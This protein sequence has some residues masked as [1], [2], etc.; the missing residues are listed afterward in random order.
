MINQCKKFR[1]IWLVFGL[2]LAN[3]AAAFHLD[4]SVWMENGA[5]NTGFCRDTALGCDTLPVMTEL[6]LPADQ[7]PT[8]YADGRKMF[9]T[10]FGD[11]PGGAYSTDD[12]GFQAL[13]GWLPGDTLLQYRA[14][15]S[16]Q[17]WDPT[18]QAWTADIPDSTQI[19]LFGG[20]SAETVISTDTSHCGGLLICIP[21]SVEETVYN[22][23]STT[24]SEQGVG[25]AQ[26]L[27]IDNTTS[28]GALHAHLDWFLEQNDGTE[29]AANGAYLVAMQVIADGYQDSVPFYILFNNGLSVADLTTAIQAR[30][31]PI[32]FQPAPV[33]LPPAF[34]LFLAALFGLSW[35]RRRQYTDKPDL[36]QLTD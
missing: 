34:A 3:S 12:P 29:G 18:Q 20:L 4:I 2:S 28:D 7:L 25:G 36:F 35:Q 11:L 33:P 10:D 24:F 6:G 13:S 27:I 21:K 31:L 1:L 26:S 32:Q 30:T 14:L 17:Y 16:L 22:E 8:D 5:I 19:R 9:L 15:E 23:A